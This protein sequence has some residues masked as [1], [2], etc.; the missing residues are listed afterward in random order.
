MPL[1]KKTED[2]EKLEDALIKGK[3]EPKTFKATGD[4]DTSLAS[5]AGANAA[6][7]TTSITLLLALGIELANKYRPYWTF[8]F[9]IG[10]LGY[11][12]ASPYE[13]RKAKRRRRRPKRKSAGLRLRRGGRLNSGTP[14]QQDQGAIASAV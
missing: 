4:S 12:Q 3:A 2:A 10:G 9:L 7:L 1:R 11:P 8:R 13:R 5:M 6:T 14:R